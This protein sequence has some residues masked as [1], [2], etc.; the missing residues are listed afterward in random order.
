MVVLLAGS[1]KWIEHR[2]A[3]HEFCKAYA[4]LRRLGVGLGA[5]PNSRT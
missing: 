1:L 5:A 4:N 2:D 3:R